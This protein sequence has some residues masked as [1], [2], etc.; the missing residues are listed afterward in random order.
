MV[1]MQKRGVAKKK[2][3]LFGIYG[4]QLY[5]CSGLGAVLSETG[6]LNTNYK[7]RHTWFSMAGCAERYSIGTADYKECQALKSYFIGVF[8]LKAIR[9][10][11]YASQYKI[12]DFP[13][14]PFKI[15]A[16]VL[17][18]IGYFQSF[19]RIKYNRSGHV[20]IHWNELSGVDSCI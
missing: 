20:D 8:S 2:R 18:D 15:M 17:A 1:F 4:K 3:F 13:F 19:Q 10:F 11:F 16:Y 12:H 7:T 5:L 9:L 14:V 6:K